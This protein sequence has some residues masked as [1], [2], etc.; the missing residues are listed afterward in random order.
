VTLELR[1]ELVAVA[2]VHYY[3]HVLTPTAGFFQTCPFLFFCG[4]G[5]GAGLDRAEGL[6]ANEKGVKYLLLFVNIRW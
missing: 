4:R 5:I 3:R 6:A 1:E 2:V